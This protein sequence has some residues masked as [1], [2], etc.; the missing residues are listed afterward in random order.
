MAR[1]GELL[2]AA[3]LLTVEQVE[4]ALRAQVMWGGRLGTN[5]IELGFLDLDALSMA[6]GRQHH[7]PAALARHFEKADR[8]LQRMLSPDVAE[9]Y[10]CIP[11]AR[12]GQ[13]RALI[14][15]ASVAPLD[16]KGLAIVADELGVPPDQLL[17]SIAAELRIRYHLERV[18]Q[19]PRGTR[20]L[21]SKGKTIP[22]FPQF[23]MDFDPSAQ[24]EDIELPLDGATA[25]AELVIEPPT[26]RIAPARPTPVAAPAARDD[27]IDF[28]GIAVLEDDALAVPTVGDDEPSGRERRR[29]VRSITEAPT[30]L[31]VEPPDRQA[32]G[33]IAIKKV[34]VSAN[35]GEPVA[36]SAVAAP[37]PT[38]A[39]ASVTA[40][41]PT[42]RTSH[43]GTLGEA[44]RAI[45]RGS[46]RDKVGELVMST[47]ETFVPT[48]AAALL[49]VVRG[50]LAIGWKGFSRSG[51]A[52]PEIGVPLNE[53][54]LVPR[55]A[56][57]VQSLRSPVTDLTPIDQLLVVSLTQQPGDLVVVPVTIG[58]Q[59][60]C[61]I[62]MVTA[63]DEQIESTESIA[64]AAGAAFARLMRDASR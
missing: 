62:A 56:Q 28:S 30:T 61:L 46:D 55:V 13:E 22:P 34:A 44:T 36:L 15:F 27:V 58:G 51:A 59:V 17:P 9:R 16:A 47:I 53:P 20:F 32:L 48:C 38:V 45:R 26:Q 8:A 50:E 29:Y 43:F 64:A 1:L 60:M 39:A 6:L 10:S 35:A 7:Q 19:I 24:S 14:A 2:V 42:Q 52:V 5:L 49:L 31:P 4:Q 37:P 21:R 18:Y 63:R 54:G 25:V 3:K 40:A 11:L 23:S 33:R 41:I 57:R 12:A